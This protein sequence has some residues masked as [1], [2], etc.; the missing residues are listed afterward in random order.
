MG[1]ERVHIVLGAEERAAYRA[2]ADRAGMS[3]SAWLRD[4]ARARLDE[5]RSAALTTVDE[6]DA[7][8]ASCDRREGDA[9]EPDWVEH[10]AAIEESRT[11]GLPR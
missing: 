4:A 9:A 1:S 10:R 5:Q 6:L 2:A 8:F 11:R 7:F 3:L